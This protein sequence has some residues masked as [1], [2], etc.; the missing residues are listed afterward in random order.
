MRDWDACLWDWEVL[1]DTSYTS[2]RNRIE[3]AVRHF[4][5]ARHDASQAQ[6]KPFADAM[7]FRRLQA[8]FGAGGAMPTAHQP[9]K[10]GVTNCLIKP[11]PG[12]KQFHGYLICRPPGGIQKCHREGQPYDDQP[13]DGVSG[14]FPPSPPFSV[15]GIVYETSRFLPESKMTSLSASASR[16]R[17]HLCS[18][19]GP[20][21]T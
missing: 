12:G 19:S 5:G 14:Q 16:A 10:G 20:C 21:A 4:P 2:I 11:N 13:G 18:K 8:I 15:C 1:A 3:G 7:L 9:G 17:S 6:K